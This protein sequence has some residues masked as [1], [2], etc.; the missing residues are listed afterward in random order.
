VAF[1]LIPF[2]ELAAPRVG[3]VGQVSGAYR[4][5]DRVALCSSFGLL[6]WPGRALYDG[7]RPRHRVALHVGDAARPIAHLDDV[8][9][10][11]M[12]VAF[13]PVDPVLAVASGS[14]DGGYFFNGELW[15]WN[16]VTGERKSLLGESRQV[17]RCRFDGDRI[18][19]LLMPPNDD[20]HEPSARFGAVIDPHAARALDRDD[21]EID[22]R[23]LD[24][25]PVDAAS[26]G[27]APAERDAKA[28]VARL[29]IEE[30]SSIWDVAVL[31]DTIA[32]AFD[33][34][35]LEVFRASGER[36]ARHQ[37]VG[38][39]AQL[40]RQPDQLLVNVTS[41]QREISRETSVLFALRG[42]KLVEW[43]KF[44]TARSCSVDKSGRVLARNT[45][46]QQAPDEVLSPD[47]RVVL[48]SRL[49]HFDAFNHA[50]RI[51]HAPDLYFLRG[52]PKN[53]HE[54]KQLCRID[55]QQRIHEV[56]AWDTEDSHLM[57]GSAVLAGGD[58]V[59]SYRVYNPRPGHGSTRVERITFDGA[60]VWR[61]EVEAVASALVEW[62]AASA[63]VFALVDTTLGIVDTATGARHRLEPFVLDGLPTIVTALA[64]HDE[65]LIA[66]TIDGRIVMYAVR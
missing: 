23:L 2:A 38:K 63:I 12:D 46:R 59:R 9:Y 44:E 30:R 20:E 39:A 31:D 66:G 7:H 27:F 53:Q 6:Y 50:V 49:G 62:P 55:G 26:F 40:V 1:P 34:G 37:L 11:I 5:R 35:R 32:A 47:G 13:H 43:K 4:D 33:D 18:A 58:L 15:W 64:V 28:E 56:C 41:Y 61:I 48:S 52:R 21:R 8:R 14:Y 65:T 3:G 60:V 19:I 36:I 29:G 57:V 10:P 22:P 17:L 51:D 24:L 42:D 54:H 25:A 16:W 45:D